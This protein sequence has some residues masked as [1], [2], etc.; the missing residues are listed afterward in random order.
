M[1]VNYKDITL[2]ELITEAFTKGIGKEAFGKNKKSQENSANKLASW[3]SDY[4]GGTE[5]L[6]VRLTILDQTVSLLK[7]SIDEFIENIKAGL[8]PTPMINSKSP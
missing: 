2:Q 8:R 1:T 5:V 6:D 7:T 4:Y 3:F